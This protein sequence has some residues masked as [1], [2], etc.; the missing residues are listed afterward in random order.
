[1]FLEFRRNFMHTVYCTSA[2]QSARSSHSHIVHYTYVIQTMII[3][4]FSAL[5]TQLL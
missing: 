4:T 3:M 1:M 2:T 5:S